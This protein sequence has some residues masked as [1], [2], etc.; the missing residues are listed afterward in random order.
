MKNNLF[1][2]NLSRVVFVA[3]GW[4]VLPAQGDTSFFSSG[5]FFPNQPPIFMG[6]RGLEFGNGHFA[7]TQ[8]GVFD[9]GG[10][11][12]VNPHQIGLWRNDGTLLASTIVPAGTA[13]TLV[14]GYRYVPISPVVLNGER[15]IVAAQYSAGDADDLVTPDI[16]R[17]TLGYVYNGRFGLG[18]GLPFPDQ[19]TPPSCSEGCIGTRFAEANFQFEIVPEPSVWL[20]VL[21]CMVFL[22]FRCRKP[23]K[24]FPSPHCK[25]TRLII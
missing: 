17:Y 25:P 20:L 18:A 8:L 16:G 12:L 6:S 1:C 24:A 21:P 7:I 9:S 5:G 10:D 2:I 11:G 23:A 3:V 15:T 22:L 19:A 4:I 13:A 14:D